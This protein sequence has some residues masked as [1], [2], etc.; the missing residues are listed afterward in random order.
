MLAASRPLAKSI[1]F[2]LTHTGQQHLT[3]YQRA[4]SFLKSQL[5]DL[6]C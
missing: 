5:T 2:K 3:K 4:R 6:K 1:D